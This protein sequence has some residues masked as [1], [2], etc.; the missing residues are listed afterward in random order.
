MTPA[1]HEA[2]LRERAAEAEQERERR[3]AEAARARGRGT[4]GRRPRRG[5]GEAEAEA[6]ERGRS[7]A[8]VRLGGGPRLL[9]DG[10]GRHA[11]RSAPSRPVGP[12]GAEV[13]AVK[14]T[15]H[16]R[17]DRGPR[18]AAG[19]SRADRGRDR[20]P[21]RGRARRP[22]GAGGGAHAA[23]DRAC[24]RRTGPEAI[25]RREI[26][27][28]GRIRT[29]FV[30]QGTTGVYAWDGSTGSR[31]SPLDGGFEPG[32]AL[33]RRGRPLRRA[34]RS[35]GPAR[36]LEGQG[37]PGRARRQESLPGGAAHELKVTLKSG[38]VRHV[39]VDAAT[40]QVVRTASTRKVRGHE[41]R[42]RP[43]TATTARPAAS[44]FARSIE[45]GVRGRPRRM[46]IDV[47]SV[48][49]N[50]TLDDSRFRVPK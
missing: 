4:G 3:E 50:P 25:V 39:W 45:I 6:G 5:P 13:S 17:R 18:R 33:G 46:R 27:R 42:S 49:V 40:G 30:F 24:H 16:P 7:P 31:V 28:P 26:A 14:R 41:W 23:D 19:R 36:R 8:L 22:G 20:G 9:A 34:G 35:R 21:A 37:P 15:I 1:E 11:A 32:A 2:I 44:R 29:E 12:A 48:E 43:S 38:A 10:T 47:E